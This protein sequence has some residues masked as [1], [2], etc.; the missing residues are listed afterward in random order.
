MTTQHEMEM[1]YA[2]QQEV[3]AALHEMAIPIWLPVSNAA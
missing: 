1:A 2:A 3:I